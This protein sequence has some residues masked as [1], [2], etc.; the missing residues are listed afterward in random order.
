[1]TFLKEWTF[2]VCLSLTAA[3]IFLLFTP[4]GSMKRFYKMLIAMFVFVSF[5]YPLR[6]IQKTDFSFLPEWTTESG[7]AMQEKVYRQTAE[8]QILSVLR[9]NSIVGASVTCEVKVNYD[10]G[11]I[12]LQTAQ[13]AVPDEYDT[14]AVSAL[15][16][17]TL[18]VRARVIHLGE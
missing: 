10:S 15:I 18:G 5:L 17:R 4:S 16:E 1:M 2:C 13:V 12:E 7:E 9:Q 8:N 14:A 3:V 6:D 11:E